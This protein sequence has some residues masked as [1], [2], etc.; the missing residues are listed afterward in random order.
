MISAK[1][2]FMEGAIKE[3][4]KNKGSDEYLIGAVIV[5]DGVVIAA[6]P[7]RARA[8]TDPTQHAE[9]AT[10]RLACKKL[11]SRYLEGCILYSTHEPCPMCVTA[12]VW[13]RMTGIVYG[14]TNQDMREA[15]WRLIGIPTDFILGKGEPKLELVQEFMREEC[16]KLFSM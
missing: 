3:A 4:V 6:S 13:A 2:K 7:A 15:G 14:V 1:K 8:E 10:I 12:A 11:G 5:K 16:K 9:I